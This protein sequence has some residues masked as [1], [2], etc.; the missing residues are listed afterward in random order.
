[1]KHSL[2]DIKQRM[3]NQKGELLWNAKY[4]VFIHLGVIVMCEIISTG[5]KTTNINKSRDRNYPNA[6]YLVSIHLVGCSV[7]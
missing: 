6:T 3:M 7:M 4:L 2:K 1:M 5:L